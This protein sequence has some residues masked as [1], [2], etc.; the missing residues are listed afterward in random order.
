MTIIEQVRSEREDLARVLKKHLGIR[1]MVE[2]LYPDSA[3]FIYELLQ[4]AE[5]AGATYAKF[6][7]SDDSLAFEH[8]GRS[9]SAEDISGITDIGDGTKASDMDKI[10]QFGVGFK[11]VFAYSETPHIWSPTFSFKISDL[12]LP[13]EIPA[14]ASLGNLT[15]FE[16]PFNNPK[17]PP[18]DA[19]DEIARGLGDLSETSLLFLADL[20]AICWSTSSGLSVEIERIKHS[21]YHVETFKKTQGQVVAR[22]H[23]LVFDELV[24]GL[25]KQRVAVAFQLSPL[26]SI[27]AFDP[28]KSIAKQLRIEAAEPGRVAIS[29][30]AEKEQSGLRFH[31]HA[32]FVPELSRASVKDTAANQPLFDQLAARAASA[33]YAIRDEGLLTADFLSVLPIPQDVIPARYQGTRQAIIH[34]MNAFPLTPTYAKTHAPAIRLLRAR[35]PIKGFLTE[36]D[37][38]F[39]VDYEGEPP[40]WAIGATQRNSNVDRF[41]TGLAAKDW[42]TQQFVE[43]LWNKLSNR[44][45]DFA[46][47]ANIEPCDVETWLA[48][49]P[50]AWHR[51]L[52][53]L[54]WEHLNGSAT[55]RNMELQKLRRVRIV[56]LTDG[57]YSVGDQCY[58][59]EKS[60]Q[61]EI[62]FPQI[63]SA[64]YQPDGNS[65]ENQAPRKFLDEIGVR[66]IDE[67]ER[68]E[69]ILKRRYNP[70]T[71]A[72]NISEI[73]RFV[74]LIE[75]QPEAAAIFQ[76]YFIIKR[77]D[78][79]W[80]KPSQAFLDS[81]FL[82]TGL[83]AFYG[84]FAENA[85]RFPVSDEYYNAGV[86][87]ARLVK[88]FKTVGVQTALDIIPTSC[89]NNTAWGYLQMASG[90]WTSTGIDRNY[91][92]KGLGQ[93]LKW[94]S[95]GLAMLIWKTMCSLPPSSDYLMATYRQNQSNGARSGISQLVHKLMIAEWVPKEDGR[96]VKPSAAA[97]DLLPAG[98]P[99]ETGSPWL[100]AVQFGQDSVTASQVHQQREADARKMGFGSAEEAAKWKMIRDL[101]ISPDEILANIDRNKRIAKP[102]QSVPNPSRRKQGVLDDAEDAPA[103]ESVRRERSIQQGVSE[104][105]ARAKAY[106]RAKYLNADEQLVCQC[107]HDE[108]PFKL[109]SGDHYFEAVQCIA[110]HETDA[111][112][113]QNRLALCPTCAAMYQHAREIDDTELRHRIIDHGT[114]DQVPA[115]EIPFRVAGRDVALYFVGTH[116]FDLKTLLHQ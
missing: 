61:D 93:A 38:E 86:D 17:K 39:L 94:P 116:W 68:V 96:F 88:F 31:L 11:A 76:N 15:R 25:Q 29:F 40:L 33:L 77:S 102:E 63:D 53:Q 64:V 65:G 92:I 55:T 26:P 66:R 85:E 62:E 91:M 84:N 80:G 36:E 43:T 113:Y 104:I 101:G 20:K 19:H 108:M 60:A 2:E 24:P 51:L 23:F 22:S 90:Y 58:Y 69:R 89:R 46:P 10:G 42:D 56:R 8:N 5:D 79:K 27:E 6:A 112:H 52:Y 82:E 28:R 98:F 114:D 4:N 14:S 70:D 1:R 75:K 30:P 54:L 81:P 78:D 59:P 87:A 32:P 9:F 110:D 57:T 67:K 109:P 97:R 35:A 115:V 72:P 34:E 47:P 99:F 12:V 107:C 106:L 105:T 73:G 83:K 7:L 16:F 3:H 13:F 111:R 50:A 74:C 48:N 44:Q 37:M 45:G 41:L 100:K 95:Q 21:D 18:A 103:F 49:K 71:F